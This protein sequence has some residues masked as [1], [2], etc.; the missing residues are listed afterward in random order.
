MST[1]NPPPKHFLILDSDDTDREIIASALRSTFADTNVEHTGNPATAEAWCNERQFDCMI[2]DY[3]LPIM[4]G[5]QFGLKLRGLFPH[6]AM[7]LVTKVGNDMLA[8]RA[9]R[10]G[11][12]DYIPKSLITPDTIHVIIARAVYVADQARIIAEQRAELEIFAYTLAHNFKQPIRQIRTFAS[13]ISDELE[14][15][16][17]AV[18]EKHLRFLMDATGRLGDLVDVMSQYTLL[19]KA[20]QIHAIDLL[21]VIASAKTA[22]APFLE[23]HGARIET[24]DTPVVM[25][26]ETLMLQVIQNLI[27]NGVKY[28]NSPTP[29]IHISAKT[30]GK[31]CLLEITDNG[32]GIDPQYHDSV[33]DP[34]VRLHT[35]AE[36]P[37]T[38]LGLTLARKAVQTQ[39]GRIWCESTPGEGATFVLEL[40]LSTDALS[41]GDAIPAAVA[42]HPALQDC[43]VL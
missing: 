33:F 31:L 19:N 3:N 11:M 7:I 18:S 10:S 5:L 24:S 8:A 16:D 37:G 17:I 39:G 28:N 29:L 26:N 36:Y 21:T 14:A 15:Q 25:G 22:V 43:S 23:E 41:V 40:L 2:I 42:G 1:H 12:S 6:I 30:I 34:L 20:P 38:G 9:L 35:A 13:L 4:D 32:I 27:V